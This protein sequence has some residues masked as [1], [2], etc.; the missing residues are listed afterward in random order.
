MNYLGFRDI[1]KVCIMNYHLSI[2]METP[3]AFSLAVVAILDFPCKINKKE[4]QK[5]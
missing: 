3:L 2:E 5:F 4:S 1:I